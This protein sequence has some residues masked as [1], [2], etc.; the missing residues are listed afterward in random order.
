MTT[1]VEFISSMNQPKS[2]QDSII[3][4]ATSYGLDDRETR[5]SNPGNI[6]SYLSSIVSRPDLGFTKPRIQLL[7]AFPGGKAAGTSS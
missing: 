2:S 3:G 7:I 5:S 6:K 4:I 1:I